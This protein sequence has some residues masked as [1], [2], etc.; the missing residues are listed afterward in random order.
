LLAV[1]TQ[2]VPHN[3]C[4]PQSE[5]HALLLQTWFAPQTVVQL[6]QWL[7]SDATQEPLQ[8]SN[9]AWHWQMRLAQICPDP[10]QGMP[11]PP[12]FA[13]SVAVFTHCAPH[14]SWPAPQAMDPPA[15]VVP[16]F[17]GPLLPE[18]PVKVPPPLEQAAIRRAR[19]G[20]IRESRTAIFI[21]IGI[22][23]RG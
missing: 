15:P 7:A 22:P 12:Q 16:P 1:S 3:V 19:L 4:T 5:L 17:P 6:P 11:H 10:E 23:G 20:A 21:D 14:T 2:A 9:P 13:G 18:A 8:S